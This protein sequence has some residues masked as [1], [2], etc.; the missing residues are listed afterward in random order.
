MGV[1]VC[2]CQETP[3]IRGNNR[4]STNKV[5]I[6]YYN[7]PVTAFLQSSQNYNCNRLSVLFPRFS[8]VPLLFSPQ[9]PSLPTL[10]HMGSHNFCSHKQNNFECAL[11][12]SGKRVAATLHS[13]C[14]CRKQVTKIE[15]TTVVISD[16]GLVQIIYEKG[17]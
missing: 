13:G 15:R 17:Y 16:E 8:F 9:F 10:P 4:S 12:C 6:G 5:A 14:F 1:C 3:P 11:N 7:F 2:V